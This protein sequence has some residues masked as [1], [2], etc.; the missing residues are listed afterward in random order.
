MRDS[1][2]V[3][4]RSAP[5]PVNAEINFGKAQLGH[6]GAWATRAT[7]RLSAQ[8]ALDSG[9][10]TVVSFQGTSSRMQPAARQREAVAL[11]ARP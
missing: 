11:L 9:M 6:G 1:E 8:E 7:R 3:G 4:E 10:D 2:K 5:T